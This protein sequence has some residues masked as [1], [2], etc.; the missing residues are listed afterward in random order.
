[1]REFE[2]V[3]SAENRKCGVKKGRGEMK[4]YASHGFL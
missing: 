2:K 1:M 4:I 3:R